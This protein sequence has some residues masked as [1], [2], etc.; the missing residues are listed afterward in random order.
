MEAQCGPE[1]VSVTVLGTRPAGFVVLWSEASIGGYA[2]ERVLTQVQLA[3]LEARCARL[4]PPGPFA[5]GRRQ[6]GLP[7]RF[8]TPRDDPSAS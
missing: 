3:R 2:L 8:C 5:L 7:R 4:W 1:E 6:A